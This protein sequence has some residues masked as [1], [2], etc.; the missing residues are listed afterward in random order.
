MNAFA[1]MN[2][3]HLI[4]Y[5]LAKLHVLCHEQPC[6]ADSFLHDGHFVCANHCISECR[7]CLL[8]LHVYHSGDT[9]EYLDCAMFS[10]SSNCKSVH[11]NRF[12]GDEV[13]DPRSDLSQGRGDDAEHPTI[14]PMYT[15]AYAFGP[16]VNSLLSESSFSACKTWMLLQV[17]TLCILRYTR[18][19]HGEPKD[20]GQACTEVKEGEGRRASYYSGRT[21][22]PSLDIQ[23]DPRKSGIGHPESN[24]KA[25]RSPDIRPSP[26]T[27]SS[28][29]SPGHP[30]PS[31][32]NPS[33]H[34]KMQPEPSKFS[35]DIQPEARTY[36]S[37]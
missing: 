30:A 17:R 7:L 16:K 12:H 2:A 18:G 37:S 5:H 29:R 21:S 8:F 10:T 1:P 34:H 28:S 27:S 25:Q 31:P 6:L 4:P 3:L 33:P 11:D 14:I 13:F 35:P 36:G 20:Q 9:L 23:P 15:Q 22:G 32:G 24:A 19:D 26:W